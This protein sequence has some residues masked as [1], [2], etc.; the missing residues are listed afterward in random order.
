MIPPDN[1][2]KIMSLPLH[3][4]SNS[5]APLGSLGLTET[6]GNQHLLLGTAQ[7]SS[8]HARAPIICQEMIITQDVDAFRHA[9]IQII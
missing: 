4:F 8:S 6:S 3:K 7:L 9:Q 1:P 2:P 5:S